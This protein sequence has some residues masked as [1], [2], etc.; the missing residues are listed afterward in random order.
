MHACMRVCMHVSAR[1]A[2]VQCKAAIVKLESASGRSSAKPMGVTLVEEPDDCFRLPRWLKALST[3]PLN[4][5]VC[6]QSHQYVQRNSVDRLA[7]GRSP[8]QRP[9][10]MRSQRGSRRVGNASKGSRR[11]METGGDRG[12]QWYRRRYNETEGDKETEEDI[13]RLRETEIVKGVLS[14][15]G[16]RNAQ[17]DKQQ[18]SCAYCGGS[19]PCHMLACNRDPSRQLLAAQHAHARANVLQ[20]CHCCR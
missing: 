1:Q 5:L 12:R 13:T 16:S 8:E 14:W 18:A 2:S 3:V 15:E 19:L 20:H 10:R 6:T 4:M 17:S 11:R 7:I 9:L